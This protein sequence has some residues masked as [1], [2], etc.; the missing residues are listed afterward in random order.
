M[1]VR[2]TNTVA[3]HTFFL[4]GVLVQV[5]DLGLRMG[6]IEQLLQTLVERP[7]AVISSEV[8]PT[9]REARLARFAAESEFITR[10]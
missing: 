1:M 8:G 9:R 6:R 4:F 5:R 7:P 3:E 2:T 10:V